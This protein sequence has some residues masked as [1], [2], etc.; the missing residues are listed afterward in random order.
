[1][2]RHSSSKILAIYEHF[3]TADRKIVFVLL[4][5]V[6]LQKFSHKHFAATVCV[7]CTVLYIEQTVLHTF[8]REFI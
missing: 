7:K 4:F 1:M 6:S 8:Q 3:L 2:K 5:P